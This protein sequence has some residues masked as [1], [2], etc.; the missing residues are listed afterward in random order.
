MAT[1]DPKRGRPVTDVDAGPSQ[2]DALLDHTGQVPVV[3]P[4]P[5]PAAFP[6]AAAAPLPDAAIEPATGPAPEP[7]VEPAVESAVEPV[8]GS[9][10]EPIAEPVVEDDV[11]VDLRRAPDV[12]STPVV[13]RSSPVSSTPPG[14]GA[15]SPIEPIPGPDP[16]SRRLVTVLVAA[17]GA[18]GLA[19]IA[20]AV[21]RSR[22][23]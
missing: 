23:S 20:R 10:V 12:S 7:I 3:T 5:P 9:V 11:E 15:R 4:G 13:T 17:L 2:V 22:T 16:R 21:R 19:A 1:Y 14:R 8:A 6:P 18:L